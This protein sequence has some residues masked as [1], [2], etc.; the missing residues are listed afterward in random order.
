M[1]RLTVEL[2]GQ[3]YNVELILTP[4]CDP[5]CM[6][7]INGQ[8]VS[9]I[10]PNSG[11]PFTDLDWMIIDERPYEIS[12]DSQLH[13]LRAFSGLHRLNIEDRE[14]KATRPRSSDGRVKAPI[15][16]LITRIMVA[17]GDIV[18]AEQP[19]LILEAM[20]MEN[21]IR[22]PFDGRVEQINIAHGQSVVMNDVLAEIA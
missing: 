10:V 3:S 15:P 19:L 6:V 4:H 1:S 18:K 17:E 14:A 5:S 8:E 7:T 21:E 16:G 9:I 12:F 13:W 11:S 22:A 2:D 20:K